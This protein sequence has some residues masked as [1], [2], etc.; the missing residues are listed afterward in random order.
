MQVSING[1]G[2]HIMSKPK[3][4]CMGALKVAV[5]GLDNDKIYNRQTQLSMFLAKKIL[6]K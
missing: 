3:T 1:I 6:S 5:L 4:L 2:T